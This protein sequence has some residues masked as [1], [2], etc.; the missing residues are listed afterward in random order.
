MLP[1]SI[2]PAAPFGYWTMFS[3]GTGHIHKANIKLIDQSGMIKMLASK[4][5]VIQQF[6]LL[7]IAI[8]GAR[9]R[10][11]SL[12]VIVMAFDSVSLRDYIAKGTNKFCISNRTMDSQR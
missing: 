8:E 9:F 11:D 5:L 1:G 7:A 12:T 6:Y 3:I 4:L 10:P 2:E